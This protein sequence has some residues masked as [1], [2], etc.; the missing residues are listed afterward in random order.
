MGLRFPTPFSALGLKGGYVS[1]PPA[2]DG[3]P[4]EL[5]EDLY[6]LL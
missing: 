3:A 2:T 1:G 4:P 6:G 5:E